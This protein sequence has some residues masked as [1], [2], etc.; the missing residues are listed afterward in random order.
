MFDFDPS[1]EATHKHAARPSEL[2][3]ILVVVALINR[4][5]VALLR[6]LCWHWKSLKSGFDYP[7]AHVRD[8]RKLERNLRTRACRCAGKGPTGRAGLALKVDLA[9]P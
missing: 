2:L 6:A 8:R 1:Q 9:L 7:R 5:N 3:L 4:R